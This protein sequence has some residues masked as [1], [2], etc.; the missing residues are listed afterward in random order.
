MEVP[1]IW[2]ALFMPIA[3]ALVPPGNVGKVVAVEL[4]HMIAAWTPVELLLVPTAMLELF[5]AAACDP[6]PET[7]APRSVTV[8]F[9][10]MT[11][12]EDDAFR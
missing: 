6:G 7:R 10:H 2:A 12:F 11:A 3:L 5:I 4:T 9:S 1:T 8:P